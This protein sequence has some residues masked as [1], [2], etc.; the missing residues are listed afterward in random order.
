MN[1][2]GGALKVSGYQ[3]RPLGCNMQLRFDSASKRPLAGMAV[4][5]AAAQADPNTDTAQAKQL[6]T[7]RDAC[8]V[9]DESPARM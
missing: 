6:T 5:A 4:A 2:V 9:W 1:L 3:I 7:P 8:Q